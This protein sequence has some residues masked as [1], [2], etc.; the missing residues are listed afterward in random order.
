ME[1]KL[2]PI[3]RVRMKK[4]KASNGNEDNGMVTY[5]EESLKNRFERFG[6]QGE[7][8][9]LFSICSISKDHYR[10]QLER[11]NWLSVGEGHPTSNGSPAPNSPTTIDGRYHP[12]ITDRVSYW[13]V[14]F[15][16]LKRGSLR[17]GGDPWKRVESE[18][19]SKVDLHQR[20]IEDKGFGE[21]PSSSS[22]SIEEI[23]KLPLNRMK[24]AAEKRLT[25]HRTKEA[26]LESQGY[27][28]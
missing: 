1:L 16:I 26:F 28:T 11:E 14:E 10:K 12:T 13:S 5:M 19:Q 21:C 9:K 27:T 2:G 15:K 22:E 18:L 6:D 25:F 24:T 17:K 7:A 4:L 23:L 20:R 8:S 3:T